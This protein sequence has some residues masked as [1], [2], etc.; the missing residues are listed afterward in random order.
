MISDLPSREEPPGGPSPRGYYDPTALE[1]AHIP[2]INLQLVHARGG[3][4]FLSREH[5]VEAQFPYLVPGLPIL[6][7]KERSCAVEILVVSALLERPNQEVDLLRHEL[8]VNA[9]IREETCAEGRVAVDTQQGNAAI[10]DYA[11]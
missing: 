5:L 7:L 2:P 3:H 10:Q 6:H 9:H 11:R 8:V 1:L 4:V